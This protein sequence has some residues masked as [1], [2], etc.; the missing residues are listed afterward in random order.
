[1]IKDRKA[2][3]VD[4]KFGENILKSHYKQVANYMELLREMGNYDIIEGYVWYISLGEVVKV[5]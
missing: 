4:Y 1:M 2:I 5:D 3:V